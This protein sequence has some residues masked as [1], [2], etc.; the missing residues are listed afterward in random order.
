MFVFNINQFKIVESGMFKCAN[1]ERASTGRR[2]T[3]YRSIRE[4]WGVSFFSPGHSLSWGKSQSDLLTRCYDKKGAFDG[5]FGP[6]NPISNATYAFLS[7]L[8]RELTTVFPDKYIH[9]GGD[10]VSFKCWW[11]TDYRYTILFVLGYCVQHFSYNNENHNVRRA[12]KKEK[13]RQKKKKKKKNTVCNG[14]LM[15]WL[16]FYD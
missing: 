5:S 9:L 1:S 13:K 8:M 10:E 6:V 16:H 11:V 14:M 4:T 2:A 3:C 15:F 12:E 7:R